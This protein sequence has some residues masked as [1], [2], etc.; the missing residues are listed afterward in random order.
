MNKDVKNNRPL[1]LENLEVVGLTNYQ[2][3][4]LTQME[5]KHREEEHSEK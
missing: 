5:L 2:R 3:M 1:V 4:V